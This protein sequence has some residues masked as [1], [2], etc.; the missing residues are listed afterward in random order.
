[1]FVVVRAGFV[2]IYC[3]R[4]RVMGLCINGP[5]AAAVGAAAVFVAAG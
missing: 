1:M 2:L 5:L 4:N 3:C